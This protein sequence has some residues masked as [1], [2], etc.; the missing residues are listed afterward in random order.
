MTSFFK[1]NAFVVLL[2]LAAISFAS[3]KTPDTL[4]QDTTNTYIEVEL[5]QGIQDSPTGSPSDELESDVCNLTE[6]TNTGEFYCSVSNDYGVVQMSAV[7]KNQD[8]LSAT[9][10]NDVTF[11][12]YRVTYTRAD[13]RNTPGVDV[14]YPFDGATNF[15]VRVGA[16]AASQA[17]I[18]VRVQA[19]EEPPL[20]NMRSLGG[21]L[22]L[23]TI[24][25]VT[26]FGHDGA[27]RPISAKGFLSIHFADYADD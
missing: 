7:L 3:C 25:E 22:A 26:F 5:V 1:T 13:G 16:G 10:L 4:K 2:A 20:I 8:Q 17:F 23:S 24:A 9:F 12:S 21:S 27:G 18:L 14:P 6:N 15:I 11:T 19:K